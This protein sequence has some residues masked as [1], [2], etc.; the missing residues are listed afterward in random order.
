[1]NMPN[2]ASSYQPGTVYWASDSQLGSKRAILFESVK[3][4]LQV[5]GRRA[6]RLRSQGSYSAVRMAAVIA[7]EPPVLSNARPAMSASEE[8]SRS[9]LAGQAEIPRTY[10]VLISTGV[11]R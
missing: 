6:K 2:F 11:V 7:S 1:M 8:S 10:S 5:L 9:D 3:V 4:L